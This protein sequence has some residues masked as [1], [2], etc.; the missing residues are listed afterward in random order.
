MVK[1][2]LLMS[3]FLGLCL[4]VSAGIPV[5][6]EIIQITNSDEGNFYFPQFGPRG[7]KIFFT[8]SNYKGLYF[9]SLPNPI[10]TLNEDPGAGY[11]PVFSPDGNHVIYRANVFKNNRKYSTIYNQKI[12]TKQKQ[13]LIQER[14][15]ISNPV[16]DK[17]G[18][19]VILNN[20]EFQRINLDL[21]T[22]KQSKYSSESFVFIENTKIAVIKDG[23]KKILAPL[24]EGHYIWPEISPTGDKLLFTKIG[25]GTYVTNIDGSNPFNLGMANAPKWSP[26]GQWI[27]YMVEYFL[28]FL[29]TFA[30]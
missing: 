27:T 1:I 3:C 16:I 12:T 23:V 24:G 19:L 6:K 5:V 21:K 22:K 15:N 20:K 25:L 10:I 11:E 4:S 7:E 18:D 2:L 13:I 26:D 14:R 17:S 30:L 29:N 9:T 28:L 8:G